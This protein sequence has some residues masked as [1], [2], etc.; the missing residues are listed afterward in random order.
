MPTSYVLLD[1]QAA[2]A[3]K[4]VAAMTPSGYAGLASLGDHVLMLMLTHPDVVKVVE[5]YT[6]VIDLI[7]VDQTGYQV[8]DDTF[9]ESHRI[10]Y[11]P[12]LPLDDLTIAHVRTMR[13]G[14]SLLDMNFMFKRKH[15]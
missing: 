11:D 7:G 2:L 9:T 13:F 4:P 14:R 15:G 8:I 5:P 1:P 6:Y 10:I 12:S 3:L